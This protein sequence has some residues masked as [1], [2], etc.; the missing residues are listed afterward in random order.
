M[1]PKRLVLHN[2]C[3]HR[4]LEVTFV[5]GLN[6]IRGPNG[7]G[8]SNLLDAMCLCVSGESNNVRRKSDKKTDNIMVGEEKAAVYM[9]FEEKG[10]PGFVKVRLSRNYRTDADVLS[11]EMEHAKMQ[12]LANDGGEDTLSED[13][14]RMVNFR[15]RETTSMRLEWGAPDDEKRLTLTKNG[16][17]LEWMT[18]VIGLQPAAIKSTIFPT[19]GNVD[20]LISGDPEARYRALAEQAGVLLCSKIHRELGDEISSQ[21]LFDGVE[22]RLKEAEAELAAADRR[23]KDA[24]A[25]YEAATADAVDPEPL[26]ATIASYQRASEMRQRQSENMAK[27]AEFETQLAEIRK[28][29]DSL[30]EDGRQK[31]PAFEEAEKAVSD[32]QL[33]IST[34][35]SQQS[36]IR[37]RAETERALAEA[38]RTLEAMPQAPEAPE[39]VDGIDQLSLGLGSLDTD[40]A[41]R[42]R[43]IAMCEKGRCSECDR[44]FENAAALVEGYSRE[45]ADLEAAKEQK[46]KLVLT[47]RTAK[48]EYEESRR[49]WDKNHAEV[50]GRVDILSQQLQSLPQAPEDPVTEDAYKRASQAMVV[51]QKLRSDIELT[52]NA[53]RDRMKDFRAVENEIKVLDRLLSESKKD[54]EGSP[55][56]QRF[57]E[58]SDK[59]AGCQLKEQQVRDTSREL[60]E[61][62]GAREVK[63][64]DVEAESKRFSR[65]QPTREW[66]G[67][68]GQVRDLFHRNGLPRDAVLWYANRLIKHNNSYLSEFDEH[69]TMTMGDDMSFL[70]VFDDGKI[71]PSS[72]L[73]GGEKNMLNLGIRFAYADLYPSLFRYLQ[74]DEVEVHLDQENVARLPAIFEKVKGLARNRGLVVPFVSHNPVLAEIADHVI[75]L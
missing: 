25:A 70:S 19:Q 74:L 31:T 14:L 23:L 33:T 1:I 35:E 5:P 11:R 63:A 65:S 60:A 55:T 17:V 73:S 45:L 9:E 26:K 40:I 29:V 3:Q 48:S 10:L 43:R 68:L 59:Y 69:F 6:M 20:S 28:E 75:D 41:D 21:P 67:L 16:E 62:R 53:Y 42:R 30:T 8:K 64:A 15:P 71:Q 37:Q 47:L 61:A 56:E 2:Y 50:S 72:R 44:E 12:V 22:E 51:Y 7:S 54:L 36:T 34:Y 24:E 13:V 39:G 18:S 32:S 58:A 38:R 52:R 57:K 27:K 46:T 66:V 4:D 49:L